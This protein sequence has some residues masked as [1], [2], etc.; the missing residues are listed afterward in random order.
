MHSLPEGATGCWGIHSY[1]YADALGSLSFTYP[2]NVLHNKRERESSL[3][4]ATRIA[5]GRGTANKDQLHMLRTTIAVP[6]SC[7]L[8]CW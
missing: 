1:E 7:N 2:Q 3:D 5:N 6:N 8:H 4:T